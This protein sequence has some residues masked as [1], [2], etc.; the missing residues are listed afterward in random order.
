MSKNLLLNILLFLTN[1][2]NIYCCIIENCLICD[3]SIL[4]CDVCE[5]DYHLDINNYN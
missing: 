1:I 4:S 3:T 5:Q 2:I